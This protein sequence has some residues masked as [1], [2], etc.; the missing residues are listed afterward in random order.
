MKNSTFMYGYKEIGGHIKTELRTVC[1]NY[2]VHWHTYFEIELVIDGEALHHLN[3]KSRK[4]GRGNLVIIAPT[5]FHGIEPL[6]PMKIWNVSFDETLLSEKRLADLTSPSRTREF[7]LNE[8]MLTRI[9]ALME[10]L[11]EESSRTEGCAKEL[12]ECLLTLILRGDGRSA[13]QEND[14]F[15]KIKRAILYLEVYFRE[16]PTLEQVAAYVNL[17][18][19]YFSELFRKVTGENFSS[20]LRALKINYAKS[21][22]AKGFSVT[23]TCYNSGFGSISNFLA[24]FKRQEG[25]SAGAYKKMFRGS[26]DNE[27]IR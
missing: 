5:D 26:G 12:C 18:P 13:P 19:H 1:S 25:V 10:L 7:L 24:A 23:D 4:I 27:K 6:S 22:L 8:K 3:G 21:L 17:N 2:G 16:N 9:V 15:S 20:H 11:S 14:R